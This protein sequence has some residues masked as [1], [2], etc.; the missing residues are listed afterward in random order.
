MILFRYI[1]GTCM[2]AIDRGEVFSL[3]FTSVKVLLKSFVQKKSLD[4]RSETSSIS[5]FE[6]PSAS[7][8]DC[9]VAW[10]AH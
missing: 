1:L 5:S 3:V 8:I 6:I 7:T 2:I 4:C 9:G 10:P